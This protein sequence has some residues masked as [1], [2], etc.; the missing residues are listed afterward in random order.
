ML[1]VSRV[2]VIFIFITWLTSL[3]CDGALCFK[4]SLLHSG[5]GGK[6]ELPSPGCPKEM[7]CFG[8]VFVHGKGL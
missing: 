3:L 6:P 7:G 8:E 2:Y 4:R 1:E 5:E